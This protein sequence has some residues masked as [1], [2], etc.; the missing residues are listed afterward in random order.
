[1]IQEIRNRF[2]QRHTQSRGKDKGQGKSR[3]SVSAQDPVDAQ[4]QGQV[5][6]T[7]AVVGGEVQNLMNPPQ[8]V[9]QGIVVQRERLCG[10]PQIS[11]AL[12]DAE[13]RMDKLLL[14]DRKSVV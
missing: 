10:P 7:L 9:T 1:M 8:A 12:L 6:A 14:R 3:R 11:A 5:E 13:Q 4:R 2:S